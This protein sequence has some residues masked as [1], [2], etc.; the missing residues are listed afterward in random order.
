MVPAGTIYTI[1]KPSI[2]VGPLSPTPV[3]L[4]KMAL[5]LGGLWTDA[6]NGDPL[7]KKIPHTEEG[8]V[9]TPT[10]PKDDINSDEAGGSIGVVPAGGA[11]ITIGFTPITPDLD[12][13]TWLSSFNVQ[14]VAAV[15][16]PPAVPAYKR[17]SLTPEGRQFRIGIEGTLDPGS[18]TEFGGFVRAFGYRVEQTEEVEINMRRTGEDAVMRLGAAVRCMTTEVSSTERNGIS[19]TDSRF[20]LFVV[21]ATS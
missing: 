1:F 14:D 4:P 6:T 13:F 18:L 8:A 5:P 20:D 2:W 9:I 16:G 21:P 19:T 12:L 3:K 10:A 15:V 17:L 7:W 11:E